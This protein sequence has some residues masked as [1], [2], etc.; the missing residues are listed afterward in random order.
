MEL[1]QKSF[2]LGAEEKLTNYTL[3]ILN[4]VIFLPEVSDLYF[5]HM[6][7]FSS[8]TLSKCSELYYI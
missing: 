4:C 6:E 3:G 7:M 1:A 8:F 2:S 5:S